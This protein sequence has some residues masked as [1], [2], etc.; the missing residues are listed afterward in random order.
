MFD[1]GPLIEMLRRSWKWLLP[2]LDRI[3]S[4]GLLVFTALTAGLGVLVTYDFNAAAER[5]RDLAWLYTL[6]DHY[7]PPLFVASFVVGI[8]LSAVNVGIRQKTASISAELTAER[9]KIGLV[10]ENLRVL[11]NG[12]LAGA[13]A[14]LNPADARA[15]MSL[16]VHDGD[17]GFTLCGRYSYNPQLRRTGRPSYPDTEG[18]IGR[19][20]REGW[21]FRVMPHRRDAYDRLCLGEYQFAQEALDNITMRSKIFT[22]K[23][24]DGRNGEVAVVIYESLARDAVNEDQVRGV[25]DDFSS[26]YSDL[27]ESFRDYVPT[28]EIAAERGF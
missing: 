8:V 28:P 21:H 19:A 15:R 20:W 9:E 7:V 4:Y 14:K 18:C 17:G 16:Y 1:V 27:L 6:A 11:F 26:S 24:I 3:V 25:L 22:A 13:S 12:L 23:R 10:S 2:K 5:H